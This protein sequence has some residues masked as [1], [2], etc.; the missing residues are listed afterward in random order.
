MLSLHS[1][2]GS[3]KLSL[4]PLQSQIGILLCICCKQAPMLCGQ[5]L[6]QATG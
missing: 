3:S 4:L 1:T 6:Q 2:S 5:T